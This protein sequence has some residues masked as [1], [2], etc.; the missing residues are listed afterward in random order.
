MFDYNANS[1]WTLWKVSVM[2]LISKIK[3]AFSLSGSI[4]GTIFP[5]GTLLFHD[6]KMEAIWL[7]ERLEEIPYGEIQ[8]MENTHGIFHWY[9]I[10]WGCGKTFYV[11]PSSHKRF[12]NLLAQVGLSVTQKKK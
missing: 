7:G 9:K 3:C 6:T 1:K 11:Q 10:C 12:C 4:L 2:F 5:C 8:S